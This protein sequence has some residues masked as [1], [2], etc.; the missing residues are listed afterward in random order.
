MSDKTVLQNIINGESVTS[1]EGATM[2]IIDPS[3]G[4]VYATS[5]LSGQQ[6]VDNA[7]A[8][9]TAAFKSWRWSSPGERQLALL[10]FADHIEANADELVEVEVQDTGKPTTLT[11]SEE[12]GPMVDQI[13]FFAGAARVLEGRSQGEYMRGHTSSIRRE[14]VGVVG[15][16]APWNYPMMMSVW[17]FAPALAAGCAVVLKPSDTTPASSVWMGKAL[18]EF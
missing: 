10:K 2:D 17:K 8:A 14:P 9:A 13:R 7:Y 11:L 5:P 15:Q 1:V 18:Q 12:I 3:T 16:V 6:D 4:A